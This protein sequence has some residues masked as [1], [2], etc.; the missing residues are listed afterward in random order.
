[1]PAPQDSTAQQVIWKN[2]VVKN[3]AVALVRHALE[4]VNPHFTTDIVPDAER[5]IGH[6]VAG[7]VMTMLKQAGVIEP[8]GIRQGATWYAHRVLSE[9]P[10]AKGRFINV[11]KLTSSQLACEFLRRNGIEQRL[12][13]QSLNLTN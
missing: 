7:T 2:D 5:G 11:Y 3:F 13:P 9:R 8:V 12:V 6:G 4:S 1:M 10:E